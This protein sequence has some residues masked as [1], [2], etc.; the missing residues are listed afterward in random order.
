MSFRTKA[1]VIAR[2]V[3]GG[4]LALSFTLAALAL[5]M[6][7]AAAT[8]ITVTT[9]A[10]VVAA[11]GLCSLRE[12]I[13]AANTD[14]ASGGMAG[15]CPA[16]SGADTINFS[17]ALSPAVFAL[18]K[19]GASED[20]AATGD[21]DIVGTLTIN[22]AGLAN[23]ILDG[24]AT[25]R[26]LDIRPGARVT[27]TGVTVRNGN[28]G[29]G[30]G[31]GVKVLGSLTMSD[32]AVQA[33]QGGGVRNE[34]GAVTLNN[35]DVLS[36]T[37]GYGVNNMQGVLSYN[38][39]VVRANQGG[40][41]R[42]SL[43]TA[44][45]TNLS[46]ISNTNGGGV[47]N[48]GATLTKL[49]LNQSAVVSNTTTGSGG[50]VFNE[51]TGATAEINGT[52]ISGNTATVG[53]GGVFNNGVLTIKGS[54]I[55]NNRAAKGGGLDHFGG[56][57]YLTNDTVS[58]NV[59]NDNG[60]G[61]YNRGSAIVAN[62]TFAGNT[63]S[64]AGTGG[65][66]FNDE[67]ELS[68]RNTIVAYSDL[69]GNCFNSAGF[70]NS[71]GYNLDSG[72]TCGFTATGDQANTNP[73]LGPLQD[74]GGLTFTRALLAGSPAIDAGNPAGCT[75][76]Q[77]VSLTTD[78]RGAARP[79]DG[80]GNGVAVCDVGAYEFG[81]VADLSVRKTS[82]PN[83]YLPGQA[84]TYTIVVT[85]AGPSAVTAITLTDNL[86]G[87]IQGPN[88]AVSQ[89]SFNSATGAWTGLSLAGGGQAVLT[90]TG[91]VDPN[92]SG[93]LQNTATVTPANASDP[94]PGDNSSTDNNPSNLQ[95]DLALGG[96]VAP[97]LI[98]PGER[99][100][101]TLVI[102]NLGPDVATT[103]VLTDALPAGVA[104]AGANIGGGG[105]CAYGGGLTCTLASLAADSSVTG[106][107]VVTTPAGPGVLIN[108]A[109]VGAG[110]PDP[111]PENN[112]LA[113]TTAILFYKS[114]LP[115]ILRNSEAI[116]MANRHQPGVGFIGPDAPPRPQGAARN[117]IGGR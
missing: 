93:V 11:D 42:N 110:T 88:Y 53:G 82:E 6:P 86:P 43:G 33:N 23:T 21:L 64:G 22:G 34:G 61:L 69:D 92:F 103:V 111:A 51:G 68:L 66:I 24:N 14:T 81:N 95:A 97:N 56:N 13:I 102:S 20:A 106:T 57:L 108:V 17:P 113:I 29:A 77:G 45:L 10:D 117:G 109:R 84:I 67:A 27:I 59:A 62:L 104:F 16:G 80:D 94:L 35:T 4:A 55:D 5:V 116:S 58:G 115:L 65:N 78:Q 83:P 112:E 38:G 28:P 50:G 96:G 101:Y 73:L 12:A 36:S 44:T 37:S 100:T 74:N 8:T 18:T 105:T 99:M 54:V 40:G 7:A 79:V 52:R 19:T 114:Y 85:N 30:L 90:I 26:V 75:D 2:L 76:A 89:G 15:E 48:V 31:G 25:D 46:V 49:T 107:V 91:T 87:E 32:S 39:G 63:S 3:V 1:M 70:L 60:G 98:G 71:L 9:A 72:N 41:V 47:Y